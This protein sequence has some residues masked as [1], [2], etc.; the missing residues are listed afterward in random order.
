MDGFLCRGGEWIMKVYRNQFLLWMGAAIS[1]AEVVTGTLIAPLGFAQGTLAIILGHVVG[2]FIFLLPAGYISAQSK[3]SAIQVTEN[4]FGRW[5]YWIFSVINGLQ[6]LG[7]TAV[8]IVNAADSMNSITK[9]IFNYQNFLIMSSI[10]TVLILIWILLDIKWFYKVNNVIVILLALVFL[11]AIFVIFKNKTSDGLQVGRISFGT[12]I[13]LNVTMALSWLPLI[14][15]YTKINTHSL[16]GTFSSVLGYFVGSAAMFMVGFLLILMTKYSDL[17]MLLA[18]SGLG[19]IPLFIIVF[20]T[21]TTTFMDASSS[22]INFMTIFKK[23]SQ[24]SLAVI[25]TIVGLII[26]LTLSMSVYEQFLYLIGSIFAPMYAIVFGNY[27]IKGKS[28]PFIFN[29]LLWVGG[30]ILYYQLQKIDFVLGTTF[31][32]AS[33]LIIIEMTLKKIFKSEH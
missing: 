15:D 31:M 2:C 22:A 24:K 4:S 14:G 30:I 12:A 19:I 6:L 10:V 17:F 11:F 18:Q 13:E 29:L 26:A 5:G 20:S 9:K 28:L 3:Q 27:L 23:M 32:T 33:I 25:I 21:V 1:I 7:W 16:K 8:M